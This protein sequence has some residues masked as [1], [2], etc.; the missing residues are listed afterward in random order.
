MLKEAADLAPLATGFLAALAVARA[1][2]RAG[3]R[4]LAWCYRARHRG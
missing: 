1:Q 2:L 3:S 4:L